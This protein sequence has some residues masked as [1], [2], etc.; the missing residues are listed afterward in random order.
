MSS[1]H[2]CP[3]CGREFTQIL[4]YPR[5]RVLDFE[6]LPIPDVVGC[7][8]EASIGGR[9][10]QLTTEHFGPDT[11]CDS[12]QDEINMTSLVA[13]ACNMSDV[14]DY[15]V[16]LE[17]MRGREVAPT[18]LLPPLTAHGHFKWA[19]PI[20]DTGIYLSLSDSKNPADDSRIAEVQ[21]H[22]DGPNLGSAGGPTL[23]PLGAIACLRYH[24]LLACHV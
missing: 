1:L 17:M 16:R 21:V 18:E 19:Y 11:P 15:L 12:R 20:A 8:S 24:G 14:Q 4:D 23:Q 5:V 9:L 22:R 10:S 13:R 2:Q 6:R 3:T 7:W